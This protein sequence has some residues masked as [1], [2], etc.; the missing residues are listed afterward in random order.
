MIVSGPTE[1]LIDTLYQ[2]LESPP[3]CSCGKPACLVRTDLHWE[4]W[5]RVDGPGSFVFQAAV[6]IPLCEDCREA[7]RRIS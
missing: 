6:A 2:Y 5:R 4:L 7:I 3:P 1:V